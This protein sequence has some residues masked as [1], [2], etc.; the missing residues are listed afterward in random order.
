MIARFR[1]KKKWSFIC[2]KVYA[3]FFKDSQ[4]NEGWRQLENAGISWDTSVRGYMIRFIFRE[5]LYMET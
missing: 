2:K 3:L 5:K 4:T 1:K